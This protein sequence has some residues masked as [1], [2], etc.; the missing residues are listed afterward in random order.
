MTG[1]TE[2]FLY[3]ASRAQLTEEVI[4][5][6]LNKGVVVISDRFMDATVAYQGYGRGLDVEVIRKLNIVATAHL[7]PDVTIVVDLS[8][9][10]CGE[11]MAAMK[12]TADRLEGEGSDFQRRVRG[13]YLEMA[14]QEPDRFCVIDGTKSIDELEEEVQKVVYP[15]LR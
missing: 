4:K 12:K 15:L 13:G 2:M 6:A 7:V 5:P 9:E 1:L 3:M 11:R 10:I 8:P 14:E